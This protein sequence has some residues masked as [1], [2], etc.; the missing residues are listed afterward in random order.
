MTYFCVCNW[1]CIKVEAT[2]FKI[3]PK[4]DDRLCSYPL[5]SQCAP[6]KPWETDDLATHN[7]LLQLK[8][9]AHTAKRLLNVPIQNCFGCFR[10]DQ[11][12]RDW[13]RQKP[14]GSMSEHHKINGKVKPLGNKKW[15]NGEKSVQKWSVYVELMCVISCRVISVTSEWL[16]RTFVY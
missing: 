15:I 4:V 2:Q 13:L 1:S 7:C 5:L 9:A 16:F 12:Q 11:M 8:V 6:S 14:I 10:R 3:Q